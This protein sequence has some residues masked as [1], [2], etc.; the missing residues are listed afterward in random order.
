MLGLMYLTRSQ[1]PED[2]LSRCN[3]YKEIAYCLYAKIQ[4]N[5]TAKN[6]CEKK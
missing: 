4:Y 3:A 1:A 2:E 5:K 6:E